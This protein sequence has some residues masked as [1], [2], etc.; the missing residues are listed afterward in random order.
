MVNQPVTGHRSGTDA[1]LL[2]SFAHVKPNDLVADL[3]SGVGVA[4]LCLAARMPNIS[5]TFIEINPDLCTLT[6]ENAPLSQVINADI[7]ARKS[8]PAQTFDHV[9]CNPPYNPLNMQ[10]SDNPDK[11]LAH[12]GVDLLE[13]VKTAAHLLHAKGKLTMIDRPERL[14]ELLSALDTRFG[15][16][17][18]LPVFTGRDHATRLLIR[19]SKGVKTPLIMR[20]GIYLPDISEAILRN[21]EA[22]T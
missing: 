19:A 4:G 5:L 18:L 6:R 2:A 1:V 7:R 10:P 21:A 17:E 9:I 15:A 8:L 13:W 16:I 20:K 3:G 12:V 11:R 14:H 22:L